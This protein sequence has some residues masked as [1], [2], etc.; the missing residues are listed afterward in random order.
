LLILLE[1][2]KILIYMGYNIIIEIYIPLYILLYH[3][4]LLASAFFWA[5]VRIFGV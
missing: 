3:A 1:F 2:L 4:G 5:S